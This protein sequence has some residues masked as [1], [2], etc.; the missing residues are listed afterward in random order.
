MDDE[1]LLDLL[2]EVRN[3]QR[4]QTVLLTEM[5]KD[6]SKNTEDLTE[7]KE[8]V[9]QNRKRIEKLEIPFVF[10]K[11]VASVTAWITGAAGTIYGIFEII[12]RFKT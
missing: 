1:I 11:R 9:I 12:S 8:G 2:R 6:I 10:T 7:H 3:E 5:R 4:G